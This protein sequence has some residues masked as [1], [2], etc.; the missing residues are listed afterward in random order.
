MM[1]K[2]IYLTIIVGLLVLATYLVS[3]AP[4][5]IYT[6][7]L[8]EGVDTRFLKMSP[9]PK[10]FYDGATYELMELTIKISI[11]ITFSSRCPL[12]IRFFR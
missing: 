10:V 4:Y 7:T 9:S 6:L 3:I 11:S 8:T 1:I 12:I 2:Y 5:H